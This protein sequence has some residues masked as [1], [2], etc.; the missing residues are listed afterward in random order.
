MTENELGNLSNEEKT[1]VTP[2]NSEETGVHSIDLTA[3]TN[4]KKVKV[5]IIKL[6]DKPDEITDIPK[7]NITVHKY[8]DIKLT[9]NEEYVEEEDIELLK[10]KFKV[11]QTWILENNIDKET[12]QLMRYHDGE[13]QNLSTILISEDDTYVYFEAKS[14]GCS[15]F[16]VVGEKVDKIYDSYATGWP[17]IPWT[18]I[19]VVITSLT[20]ILTVVFFKARIIYLDKNQKNIRSR[21]RIRGCS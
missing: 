7:K 19:I 21:I 11:E 14:P 8:L 3:V 9:T 1:E 4:L 15:T 12:I 13:W 10:F 20:L 6:K 18:I 16:A 2:E 17:D 5:K